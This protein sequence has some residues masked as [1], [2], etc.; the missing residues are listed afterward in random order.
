MFFHRLCTC[1]YLKWNPRGVRSSRCEIR[2]YDT[3]TVRCFG[4]FLGC[5]IHWLCTVWLSTINNHV[6]L[7]YCVSSGKTYILRK[8]LVLRG[9][10]LPPSSQDSLMGHA[11]FLICS[12]RF[13]ETS[14]PPPH[15]VLRNVFM[16]PSIYWL[17]SMVY[18]C[19]YQ[20]LQGQCCKFAFWS[21]GRFLPEKKRHSEGCILFI[22]LIPARRAGRVQRAESA[23]ETD[24]DRPRQREREREKERET[25]TESEREREMGTANRRWFPWIGL[26]VS[27]SRSGLFA[28]AGR[29]RC[30]ISSNE[31]FKSD[32]FFCRMNHF[33][34]REI[35]CY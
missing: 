29:M 21:L 11:P 34:S 24:C 33:H 25:E 5:E 26:V 13:G 8:T 20:S 19:M 28:R 18:T 31:S 32:M 23:N 10:Y 22:L 17:T 30:M 27:A 16:P 9:P 35:T 6:F 15:L 7:A 1:A 4:P 14:T 12:V 2:V 3:L